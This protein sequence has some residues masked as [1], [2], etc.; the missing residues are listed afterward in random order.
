MSGF[1][2]AANK[3]A[4]GFL[5]CSCYNRLAMYARLSNAI[6]VNLLQKD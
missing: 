6:T 1:N 4:L 3:I 5:N 2:K